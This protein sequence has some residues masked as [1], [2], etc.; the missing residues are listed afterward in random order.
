MSA[1]M[2]YEG[3]YKQVNVDHRTK[4]KS[5]QDISVTEAIRASITM[6]HALCGCFFRENWSITLGYSLPKSWLESTH[7]KHA[8][9]YVTTNNPFTFTSIKDLT[10]IVGRTTQN[11]WGTAT[12]YT[13]YLIGAKVEF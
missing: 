10:Q 3:N 7:V 12:G 1:Y 13:T 2:T 5:I 8:R 11:T 9:L 4:D 6:P